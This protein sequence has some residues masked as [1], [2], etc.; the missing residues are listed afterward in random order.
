V[1]GAPYS[2]YKGLMP[3]QDSD[4]DVPFFFGRDRE[5]ELVEANLMAS[6][7]TVLYGETGVGKSSLLR[8]GVAHHLRALASGN[9][10]ARGEPGLAVVVF[11][12]WRDDPVAALRAAVAGEVTHALGGSVTPS[13]DD[14][15]SLGDTLGMWQELLGGDLYVILDQAE[16]YFLYHGGE[17]GGGTFAS[18]FPAVVNDAELRVNFVLAV[19]DDSL[20]KLDAFRARIPNVFGNYLRLEHLDRN[21]ARAAVVEPVGEYN[22][23]VG[24]DDEVSIEPEL[25]DAVLD[26]VVAGKVDVGQTGRGAVESVNGDVRIETSYLQLVLRRLWDEELGA[27]SHELRLATLERLGGAEQIVRDHVERALTDLSPE[28]KDVAALLF[29]HLVTP[30]GTKIAHEAADLAKYAGTSQADVTPVLATLGEERILRSVEGSGGRDSRYEIFHDVLA[31]PVLAWKASHETSRTLEAAAAVARSRHRRLILVSAL[32]LVALVVLAGLTLFA[33]SQRSTSLKRERTAESREL[34]ASALTQADVDPELSLLLALQAEEVQQNPS[35]DTVLRTAL[36][37]SRVRR[38]A[39]VGRPVQSIAVARGGELVVAT[40]RGTTEFDNALRRIRHLRPLGRFLGARRDDLMFLT[41]RGLELR[42]LDGS[43]HRLIRVRAGQRLEVRNLETGQVVGTVR[44]PRRIKFAAIGP[45]GTL[46]AVSNGSKRVVVV[47]AETGDGRYE[48][49]Q[50]ADVTALAFGPGAHVLATGGADGTVRVWKIATGKAHVDLRGH[51]GAV[52]DLAFSPRATLL[53]S[54]SNDGTARVFSLSDDAPVSVMSGHASPI[55]QVAFSPDGTRIVTASADKTARVWKAETGGQLALLRGD[56][57]GVTA[58]RFVGD[59]SDVVTGSDDGKVKLWFS[60]Q[61][62]ILDTLAQFVHRVVRVVAL[63]QHR[64]VAVTGDGRAHILDARGHTIAIRQA[65]RARPATSV[66]GAVATIEGKDV[67]ITEPGGAEVFLRGHTRQVSSARFSPDGS[68]AVTASRDGTAR[69]W[70]A[71]SGALLHTLIGHFRAV[72]DAEF[73][74]DGRWVVTA[75]AGTAGIWST[76]SGTLLYFLRGHKGRLTSATFAPAGDRIYT[77]GIDGTVRTY[78]CAECRSGAALVAVA[79]A[80]VAA[81]G[82]ALT[83]AE[84]ARF[85]R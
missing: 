25:V 10:N 68:L 5:R 2:P 28:E 58:A 19:R 53:A 11:D 23:L 70:D 17:D 56:Q 80:R 6:R 34:A 81:T 66:L 73:S 24:P 27:G 16:E 77:A 3:F 74:A 57:G 37:E 63:P 38:V 30:S 60:L 64:V 4:G 36:I 7:L 41:P 54:V 69:I 39:S 43:L 59:G 62:P 13:N 35:V 12:A 72:N 75:G 31:E 46:L 20:A 83:P 33:F 40:D 15:R 47:N 21:A 67:R 82:R 71:G 50:A 14:G 65:P 49:D 45:R 9:R 51:V 48:I 18:D 55:S 26:Q 42:R 76:E 8:A 22:R 44:M 78:D 29:D 1:S 79:R 32:S 61:Q 85:V 52:R 84:R